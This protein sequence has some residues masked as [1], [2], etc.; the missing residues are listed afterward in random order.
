MRRL[1]DQ[2]AAGAWNETA[3]GT[4]SVSLPAGA[5][6]IEPVTSAASAG[7]RA[8]DGDA[9]RSRSPPRQRELV[10]RD[11]ELQR[12]GAR[13]SQTELSESAS[14][15]RRD[16]P[17]DDR[18][19]GLPA[20]A[21]ATGRSASAVGD[22]TTSPTAPAPRS[23]RRRRRSPSRTSPGSAYPASRLATARPSS[24]GRICDEQRRRPG[25]RRRRAAGAVHRPVERRAVG[26]RARARSSRARLPGA[27]RFGFTPPSKA[28]PCD[29]NPA[30]SP[31]PTFALK[32][33]GADR[34]SPTSMP[35]RCGGEQ[36]ER[37]RGRDDDDRD[38]ERVRGSPRASRAAATAP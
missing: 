25:D 17:D 21:R 6:T 13:R 37:R 12:P 5:M 2:V 18:L 4:R 26:E 34:R 23:Q 7:R 36:R 20:R 30:T 27:T 1:H 24:A 31:R 35:A 19:R 22:A 33:D 3:H 16:V 14:R 8:R 9:A 11:G 29:E 10:R 38:A 15:P 28:R 32:L